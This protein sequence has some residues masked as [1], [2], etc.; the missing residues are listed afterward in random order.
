MK[1][2]TSNKKTA[3]ILIDLENEWKNPKSDYYI[4]DLKQLIARTN[5]LI[6]HARKK[7]WKIIFVRHVEKDS[8]TTF[9]PN[10]DGIRIIPAL[11]KNTKD[12]LI[13][14]YRIN[15]FYKTN[16]EKELNNIEHTI[17]A[18]ILTN[19]CVRMFVEEAYDRGYEITVVKDCCT[20]MD[21]KTHEFTLNDLKATREEI[22]VRTLKQVISDV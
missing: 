5:K 2:Q 9:A 11:K 20:A 6:A 1:P 17:V 13:T 3:L 22:S 19:L 10:S 15:A 16:L 4:G 7:N 14:K 8:K 12:I 21:E 18:G